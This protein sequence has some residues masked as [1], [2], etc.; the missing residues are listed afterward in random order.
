MSWSQQ[1]IAP[2]APIEPGLVCSLVLDARPR[3]VA[4]DRKR[5]VTLRD[6][7]A[8]LSAIMPVTVTGAVTDA[9]WSRARHGHRLR[10]ASLVTAGAAFVAL[11]GLARGW[12]GVRRRSSR[13][14]VRPRSSP[15][16]FRPRD[17]RSVVR[18]ARCAAG[19]GGTRR[20][21]LP[22]PQRRVDGHRRHRHE[23][24][25]H[26]HVPAGRRSSTRPA[27]A[28]AAWAPSAIAS[29]SSSASRPGRHRRRRTSSGCCARWSRRAARRARWRCRR[30]RW[31]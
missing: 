28:A 5:A 31:R 23:R 26:Q 25:D 29:A 6:L 24:Q 7:V 21:V 14:V 11:K 12:R 3:P 13:R 19:A 8:R 17:R 30:T 20:R 22:A 10:L 16:R 15:S 18:R 9:A 1:D 2:G 4:R 27:T